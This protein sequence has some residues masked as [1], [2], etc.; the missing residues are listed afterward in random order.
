MLGKTVEKCSDKLGACNITH[1]SSL[2]ATVGQIT[3][4]QFLYDIDYIKKHLAVFVPLPQ[5]HPA[6][7]SVHTECLHHSLRRDVIVLSAAAC[8]CC[9]ML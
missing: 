5:Q 8:R 7:V 2:A 4:P 9:H 6:S 3:E 1:L